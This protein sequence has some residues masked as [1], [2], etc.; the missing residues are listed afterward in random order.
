MLSPLLQFYAGQRQDHKGRS[1]QDIWRYNES[2]LEEEHDYIQWLFPL[3][4]LGQFFSVMNPTSSQEPTIPVLTEGDILV[5]KNADETSLFLRAR[6][7][8]SLDVMLHFYGFHYSLEAGRVLIRPAANFKDRSNHWLAAPNHNFLR[9][10]RILKCLVLV[11]LEPYAALFFRAL[12]SVHKKR[13]SIVGDSYHY[14]ARA[15][16]AIDPDNVLS[17]DAFERDCRLI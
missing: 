6:I 5:L 16:E 4:E 13:A 1:I 14:W 8:K 11:G 15:V 17:K 9:I 10:T 2:Q 7:L 12:E 3:R